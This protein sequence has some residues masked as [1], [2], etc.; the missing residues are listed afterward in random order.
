M[1]VVRGGGNMAAEPIYNEEDWDDTCEDDKVWTPPDETP[2]EEPI[3]QR[4]TEA[5]N[6]AR[7]P[8]LRPSQF[9]QYAFWMP[10]QEKYVDIDGEEAERTV[11]D[12]FSFEGRRHMVRCYDT[13]S[14]RLLLFC[15]RQVEK[16]TL[17]GNIGLCYMSLI[18][19]FKVL[20][21]SPSATQTKTFSNDRV[22]EPLETSPVLKRF[23]T[24]MLSQNIFEKQFVN[25]SKITLRYAYLNADRT[26]GVPANMLEMDEFQDVLHDNVPVIEQCLSHSPK[27]LKRQVY[28]GTPKSLDNHLEYYR[29]NMSTQG[30]WAVPCDAHGG[31]TGRYWNI[32]GEKNIG[33]RGL[34][35]E[36][37][38]RLINPM[39]PE[40]QWV[41]MVKEAAWESYRIP[42]LMVPWVDWEHDILYNY[43]HYGRDKFY[44]ECLGLS[45]D[46]GLRPLT[47]GQLKA[48]CNSSLSMKE[49]E[50]ET[51]RDL[52]YAQHIY[53]GIDWGCHDEDTRILTESGFKYFRDLTDADKVAQWDP[54]TREMTF[55]EPKVRT[56]RDWD[57]PLLH[58]K[59]KGGVDM[60]VTHTH[61][62]RVGVSQGS[63]WLTES[64]GDLV[65]R[66][67]NVNFVGHVSWKGEERASFTLPGLS[68]SPGYSGSEDAMFRMDDWLELLGYL[69]TEGGLCF[70]GDR[71]SCLKMSQRE[72]VNPATAQRIV[73]CMDRMGVPYS[74]FPNP[75]TGDVNWTIRGKQWWFWWQN[76]VGSLGSEKRLPREFLQLSPR[77]LRI[78]FDALVDGDGT[79]D[80][81]EGC[82]GGAFYSTSKGLCED[83]QELCLRLGLRALLRLHKP[84]E[85]NRKTRWRVLWSAGRDL[86]LNKPSTSVERV[87]YRG[88][89]YCCSVPS[90]Y[91]VTERNGCVSYQGNTGEHTYTVIFLGTYID[92]KFR[93]FFAHRFTGEEED[94][95][96]QVA[97]IIELVRY[98]NVRFIGSDYGGGFD[99]NYKLMKE[100]G[101][102]RLRRFQYLARS[103]KGKIVWD[104]GL[105]RYKV[106][107]TEVM[108]DIFNA[109]KQG[110]C[111]FPRLEEFYQPYGQDMLN[112]FSEMNEQL[113]MI[114]YKHGLDM[115]DDSFHALVYCW[116]ASMMD[117]PRPDIILPDTEDAHGRRKKVWPGPIDQS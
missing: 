26:R 96:V 99:R 79:R 103:T 107:R 68:S 13:P 47:L 87:P 70:N 92:M 38:H 69:L 33:K 93:I 98:F 15:A 31:E 19:Q 14:K 3:V 1:S 60:M 24:T 82:T 109:V 116:L 40:A 86:T 51:Y 90:G 85:G 12:R 21:V 100:F 64:A 28:A 75:V 16:S 6:V 34:V 11:I 43:E 102:Q 52:S 56:V 44:N 105:Q 32:L 18:P 22:K 77:Q 81:R 61:R 67:G 80:S 84:A 23:T 91:I 2:L 94:P 10:R 7:L 55:V 29:A 49:K 115:P 39:H 36:K 112:I 83:F 73:D 76:N 71:P 54:D 106:A 25:W 65:Q 95:E 8:A 9:T 88:K 111:E 63:R 42:Q 114:Q 5:A 27:H 110:K 37:C 101:A 117:H 46:S 48:V 59:T 74:S 97:R 62:M 30:E 104:K 66:G 17:L 53:A 108:S 113:R 89:V 41:F 57:Q 58:F 35:C 72:T 78:L 20:Y 45:Y 4:S 50:L